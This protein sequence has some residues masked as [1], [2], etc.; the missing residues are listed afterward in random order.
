MKLLMPMFISLKIAYF[1]QVELLQVAAQVALYL[2]P[3]VLRQDRRH[4]ALAFFF[5]FHLN[6]AAKNYLQIK[7]SRVWVS[8]KAAICC[9]GF[10]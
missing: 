6:H 10:T 7:T 4:V 8:S 3:Q 5:I 2:L 9:P 1:I